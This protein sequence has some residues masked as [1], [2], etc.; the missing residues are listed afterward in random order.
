MNLKKYNISFFFPA[1]NDEGTIALMVEDAKKVLNEVADNYEIII[2]DDGSPDNSGLIADKM[3]KKY[4]TVKVIHH[5]YNLG[6]GA[7]LKSGF[8]NAKYDLIFY[9]DGDHQFDI[10]ELK[11]FMPYIEEYDLIAGYRTTRAYSNSKIR[12]FSSEVYNFFIKLVFGLDYKD[13]D[14]AFK[15]MKKDVVKNSEDF[16]N[17]AFICAILFYEAKKNNKKIMQLP[18][19]HYKRQYGT[20]SSFSFWFIIKSVI[21]L[22]EAVWNVKF[23]EKVYESRQKSLQKEKEK[24]RR[25]SI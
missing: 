15:L 22:F 8:A 23:R 19:S 4:E 14:C 17:S 2:I 1:F 16:I 20:S 25:N 24:N 12:K 7:A 10:S 18:V 5:K 11:S 13:L 6:Y 9:T 3:A 21:E